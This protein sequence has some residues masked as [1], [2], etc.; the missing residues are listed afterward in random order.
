MA[1]VGEGYGVVEVKFLL[2][3]D[4]K[5]VAVKRFLFLPRRERE[6]NIVE[7]GLA[8]VCD[9]VSVADLGLWRLGATHAATW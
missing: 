7:L 8:P 4:I 2:D 3:E 5:S 6:K 9:T 1:L